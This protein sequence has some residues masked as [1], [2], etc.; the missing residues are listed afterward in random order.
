MSYGVETE[1]KGTRTVRTFGFAVYH[2]TLFFL[3]AF[4]KNSD[5]CAAAQRLFRRNFQMNRNNT[6]PS[7]YVIVTR[8]KNVEETDSALKKASLETS[9]HWRTLTF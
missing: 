2:T 1:H 5:N 8:I 6:V 9:L 4:D 3:K 7:A